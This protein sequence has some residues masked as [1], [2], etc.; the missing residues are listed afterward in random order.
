[1]DSC[2]TDTPDN[3]SSHIQFHPPP[4]SCVLYHMP[5]HFNNVGFQAFSSLAEMMEQGS[6]RAEQSADLFFSFIE[7]KTR[8]K[9][10]GKQ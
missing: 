9:G 6:Y 7:G 4:I 3:I 10:R 8:R 1:M 5:K 2:H